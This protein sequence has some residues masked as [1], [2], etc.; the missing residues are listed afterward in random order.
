MNGSDMIVASN[1]RINIT[2]SSV[3]TV[4]SNNTFVNI[5]GATLP[6][7]TDTSI[8]NQSMYIYLDIPLGTAA[9]KYSSPTAWTLSVN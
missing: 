6:R 5:T 3:G 7:S 2:N 4:L 8:G 1:F 9:R